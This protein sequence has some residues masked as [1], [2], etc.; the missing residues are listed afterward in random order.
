M[1]CFGL[2]VFFISGTYALAIAPATTTTPSFQ[3]QISIISIPPVSIPPITLRPVYITPVSIRPVSIPTI[4]PIS[5]DLHLPT[6][7]CIQTITPDANGYVPPGT[8]NALYKYYPSFAAAVIF[9]ALFGAVTILHIGQAAAHKKSFCW[10]IIM[11]GLWETGGFIVRSLSTRAQQLTG[12]VLASELLVL[13]APL[14]I[15]AF[16]Y[17]VL[18][19]MIHFFLPAHSL[20]GI[21]ASTLALYFV[22]L[23]I[24]SF[25]IQLVGGA[26]GGP[27]PPPE[28]LLKGVH[29]YMGGIGMQE[30]FI[31]VFLGLAVR[32]HVQMLGME[33]RG[34][35]VGTRKGRWRQLLFTLYASLALISI[36]IFFRLIEFSAGTS[37]SNPLPY[38]EIYFYA[39]DAVP[40]LLALTTM[41]IV[42]PGRVLVGP[43]S[44]LPKM[45]WR[46]QKAVTTMQMVEY[47]DEKEFRED[48]VKGRRVVEYDDEKEFREDVVKGRRV[49][50]YDDEKEL[51]DDVVKG[52]K[53][54][55][56]DDEKELRGDVVKGREVGEYDDEKELLAS[57]V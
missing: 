25:V 15:N 57:V 8:C 43:D 53:V 37:S 20:F 2:L 9:S 1:F 32:F 56:Y 16:D 3:P 28:Q 17:M 55:E 50:E 21:R 36:R 27:E 33:K 47:D 22:L 19:R 30:F 7:T 4:T 11:G 49:G 24:V 13:L 23:D 52:R 14:W 51:R 48:L 38:H 6:P 44:E 18:G 10:V 41:N 34:E 35:L 45:S 29:I 54:G 42:H 12:L 5:L 40:M 46:K 26:M 39:F 31:L